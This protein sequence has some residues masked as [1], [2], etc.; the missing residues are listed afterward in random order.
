MIKRK[1]PPTHPGGIMKRHYLEPLGL[2]VTEV[3]DRLGVSRKTVSA[4]VNERA[5]VSVDMALRLAKAFD[6]SPELWVNLQQNYDLWHAA[7]ETHA[8]EKIRTFNL[9]TA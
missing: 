6:T 7:H 5:P 1:R 4:I 9:V 8:W 2:T 3:A